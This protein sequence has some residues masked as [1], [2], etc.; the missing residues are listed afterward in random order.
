MLRHFY[1]L[2]VI[3]RRPC[4]NSGASLCGALPACFPRPP[5]ALFVYDDTISRFTVIVNRQFKIYRKFLFRRFRQARGCI[6][7]GD[8]SRDAWPALGV[9]DIGPGVPAGLALR[10]SAGIKTPPLTCFSKIP[11]K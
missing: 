6:Q 5:G 8:H 7:G 2:L 4:Y 11:E 9:G 10:V 1:F 3:L